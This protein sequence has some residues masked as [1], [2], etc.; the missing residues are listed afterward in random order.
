MII[1]LALRSYTLNILEAVYSVSWPNQCWRWYIYSQNCRALNMDY[2][3]TRRQQQTTKTLW[4]DR[5]QVWTLCYIIC[6]LLN[7]TCI[8]SLADF[9]LPINCHVFLPNWL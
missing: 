8:L 6:Y 5:P 1:S 4:S 3:H 9:H 7:E 2:L